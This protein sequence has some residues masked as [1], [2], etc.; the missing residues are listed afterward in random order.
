MLLL[1]VPLPERADMAVPGRPELEMEV[2]RDDGPDVSAPVVEID[3]VGDA[4]RG[5][6][7][8]DAESNSSLGI[9]SQT[10]FNKGRSDDPYIQTFL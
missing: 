3:T 7:S 6:P 9:A 10:C 8:V 5:P 1:E 2:R 4:Q